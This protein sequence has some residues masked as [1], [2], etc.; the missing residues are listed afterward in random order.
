MKPAGAAAMLT[1]PRGWAVAALFACASLLVGL[2]PVERLDLLAYD[3]IEPAFRAAADAPG[4]VV[5]AIDEPTL[6]ALGRWPW[7]RT[8][9]A[10]LIDRLTVS[11]VAA[12]GMPILFSEPAPGDNAFAE[13]LA[14]SG[15]VVL[16]VAP[17]HSPDPDS[18]IGELLP[19]PPLAAGAARI[20]HVDVEVDA[21]GLARRIFA[22][23]G[24]GAPSW[25]AFALAVLEQAENP[26]RGA[27]EAHHDGGLRR[28]A[29][30]PAWIRADEVLL[31]Y[32]DAASRPRFVSYFA[33]LEQAE[34]LRGLHGQTVFIGATAG[35]L[36]GALATPASAHEHPMSAVEFHARAF[37]AL[38]SG[39]TYRS[40]RTDLT[41]GLT[42]LFIGICA[43][44]MRRVGLGGALALAP[45]AL[46]PP[47]ASGVALNTL[48]VW[49]PP[50][51]AV[52]AFL[53]G[54]LIWF[55]NHLLHTRGSL[56]HARHDADATLRSITDG[57][58]TIDEHARITMLN[59]VAERLSGR[60]LAEARGTAVTAF[61]GDFSDDAAHGLEAIGASLRHRQGIR[62][63][64][65]LHW[66]TPDGQTLALQLT[67]T[68]VGDAD[69]GSVIVL[70][71]ITDSLA[72]TARLRHEATHDLLTGLPNRALLLDRL[73]QALANAQRR[74]TLVAL[75]FVDLDRF[76][77]IND[78]LGDQAGDQVLRVVA[79]RLQASVRSGDTVARWGGD[80][81]IIL[82]DNLR[83][84]S[85]VVAV[86]QKL[87]ELLD[88]EVHTQGT[89]GLVVSCSIGISVGP[90]DSSDAP[91]LLSMADKAMYRG[92]LGGGSRYTFYAPEMNTWSRDRLN[93]ESA[94]RHGLSNR[95]FELFYQPQIDIGTGQ[96][97]GLES[98]I[99]WH[100]PGNGIV[101]P[102]AFIPAAE[103]SGIICNIGDWA[104][105]EAMHQ[106]A[107]W[108]AEGLMSVPLAVNVSARQCSDMSIVETI[109][110]AL[111]DSGLSAEMLKIEVT[112]S[113]AMRDPERAAELLRS[114][115]GLGVGVAVDDF[116]TGY[117]SLSLLKRFP[118][119]EL[120]IDKSFVGDIADD[121]DDAA[122]VRG[123]I[124][125]A[126]GL[127]MK[128]VAEGVETEAQLGFLARHGCDVVQGYLFAKPLPAGE[129]RSW[130]T[131]LPP[132]ALRVMK[133]SA[134]VH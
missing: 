4:S 43:T 104:I 126:H 106:V 62:L 112:E 117:S 21:D 69:E 49:I 77:R 47:L 96:L 7:N 87:L 82:M 18:G 124:A 59:P 9:H 5:V 12:I 30:A 38:R 116:G 56:E 71:D 70:N 129:V 36:A 115:H 97:S 95:E 110:A 84:R 22:R 48:Q 90:Q 125:L 50:M 88:R 131:R 14:A 128:V 65:P 40:A 67:V 23:A 74:G 2:A 42:L 99:R 33:L 57:V 78:S 26:G 79:E 32:P 121:N 28:V 101:R 111:A 51:S 11:G 20:G 17:V 81:F 134:R 68:P 120:K 3:N 15:R 64:E 132:H 102:D 86:A 13:A 25:H 66:H 24:S 44:L 89:T 6:A 92:K 53:L 100:R 133:G 55:G 72:F 109:R 113:T 10:E 119:S 34:T 60:S 16:P 118:I 105:T 37:E 27:R 58:I 130:L 29:Q 1:G 103:E 63:P 93:L 54:Y 61:L 8:V 127:G 108:S 80:E 31:P 73:Q 114:I 76:K 91:T 19:T 83:D 45:L 123:T 122:I 39:L 85:A 52:L 35:G 94:L 98:L 107:R 46:V 75:L 41:L